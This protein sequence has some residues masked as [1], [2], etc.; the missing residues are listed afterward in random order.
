MQKWQQSQKKYFRIVTKPRVLLDID[1][2]T[3]TAMAPGK[4][5]SERK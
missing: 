5:T 3:H 4:I 1:N 2:D